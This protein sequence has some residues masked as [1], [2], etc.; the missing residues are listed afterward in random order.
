MPMAKDNTFEFVN[1]GREKG[2]TVLNAVMSDF[3][4]GRHAHEEVAL[5]VT[6]GGI[7]EFSCNGEEFS[8]SPG[9]IILFNPGEAHNGNPGNKT[10]LEYTMLYL[11]PAMFYGLARSAADQDMEEYRAC[12]I[13]FSD[14]VLRALILR[15]AWLVA[16]P[17]G[18]GLEIESC[19]YGLAR[20][21]TSRMGVYRPNGWI[22]SK[23]R[24]LLLARDYIHDNIE[25]DISIDDLS[26]AAHLS[27]YHF[28]RLFRSQFGLT[29]HQYIINH[30]IN[31]VR[32][33]LAKATPPTDVA[34]R[35]G[36]FDVS[37]MNRH[38]K[39]AY[40]LTPRQYQIQL[41]K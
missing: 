20:R 11:D 7:Q 1:S 39:R 3:A 31:R 40:G 36:F 41:T 32:E 34:A 15:T 16:A 9:D 19:L 13:N 23:D 6:L 21:L 35:F 27:K 18:N 24:L 4:Y 30:R 29:P 5:G 26:R 2:V 25:G 8:S 12:E 22:A 37:H 28:I 38:F 17:G 14:P 33:E 10:A